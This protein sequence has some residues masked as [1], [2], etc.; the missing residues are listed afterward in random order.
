[1]RSHVGPED[2]LDPG[3]R[4][5]I[6]VLTEAPLVDLA[7]MGPGGRSLPVPIALAVKRHVPNKLSYQTTNPVAGSPRRMMAG[8]VLLIGRVLLK[9]AKGS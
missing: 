9:D 6:M 5:R 3:R 8:P 7:T 1:M 2:L 4:E